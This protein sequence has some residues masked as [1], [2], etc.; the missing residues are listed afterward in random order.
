[1][2]VLENGSQGDD[3]KRLQQMLKDKGFYGGQVNGSFGP[4]TEAAVRAFQTSKHL[5]ADGMAGVMTKAA[6]GIIVPPGP[7]VT[8][9]VTA[10]MV[11]TMMHDTSRANV[12]VHLANVL[13]ALRAQALGDRWMVLMALATIYA[14]TGQFA[15]IPEGISR[16]NTS[17]DGEPFDLYDGRVGLGNHGKPDGATFKGRGFVQV[18]GRNNYAKYSAPAGEDLVA[19][20]DRALDSVIA[21]KI[22][23]SYMKDHET[24]I[25]VASAEH[26]LEDLR[27]I[28]NG[29]INGID[30]FSTAYTK[31]EPLIP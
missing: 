31:G 16:F 24:A 12:T 11:M 6:L 29:G 15:P 21:S 2:P 9:S 13:A 4:D 22:L 28:V 20:P 18:T 5:D 3:V 14:E 27:R 30:M 23:A 17:P 19:N 10:A 25:R 26:E 7:D 1:M 8:A